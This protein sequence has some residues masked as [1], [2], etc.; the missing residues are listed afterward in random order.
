M[1]DPH[2]WDPHLTTWTLLLHGVVL[3]VVGRRRLVC[4]H[5][6]PIRWTRRQIGFY[7]AACVA[8]ATALTWPLAD[9]AAHWSLTALVTQRLILV[10]A[11]APMLL[12]GLPYDLVQWMTRPTAV[13][14]LLARCQRPPVAIATVSI[15]LV[16]SMTPALVAAQASSTVARGLLDALMVLARAPQSDEESDAIEPLVWADVERQFERAD[17]RIGRH[18]DHQG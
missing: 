8:S 6:H 16:T 3:V 10:L 1:A 12:L 18:G 9:L 11:V 2:R 14:T 15:L 17:R 13:D 4:D 5:D 7:A